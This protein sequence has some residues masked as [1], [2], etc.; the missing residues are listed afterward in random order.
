VLIPAVI[1]DVF[2]NR[3][4]SRDPNISFLIDDQEM[5]ATVEENFFIEAF[6]RPECLIAILKNCRE[7]CAC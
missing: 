6:S 7:K 4:V 3:E 2:D 1:F 5:A